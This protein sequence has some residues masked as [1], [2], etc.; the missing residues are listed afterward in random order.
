[1]IQIGGFVHQLDVG[2]AEEKN[3]D[4]HAVFETQGNKYRGKSTDRKDQI[5]PFTQGLNPFKSQVGKVKIRLNVEFRDPA[6]GP[7]TNDAPQHQDPKQN[8][9]NG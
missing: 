1:M 6:V 2:K 7:K 8:P 3:D 5:G 4:G 9:K